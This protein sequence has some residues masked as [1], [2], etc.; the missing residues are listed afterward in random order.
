M[1]EFLC[2][3]RFS[4]TLFIGG[5]AGVERGVS[6]WQ[7]SSA[8]CRLSPELP[9]D[10]PTFRKVKGGHCASGGQHFDDNRT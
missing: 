2:T 8:S 3:Q 9:A 1:S 10:V 7:Q 6:R 5:V 4:V